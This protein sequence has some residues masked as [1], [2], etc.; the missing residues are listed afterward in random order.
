MKTYQILLVVLCVFFSGRADAAPATGP[1]KDA[2][3]A[4]SP[5][6]KPSVRAP[7]AVGPAIGANTATPV[8]RIKAMKDFKVE[9]IYSV[10][11][12]THGSW[13]NLCNDDKGRIYASD[14]YG[15]LFRLTPPPA[16]QPLDPAK[17]EKVPANIRAVNGMA[18][19]FGASTSA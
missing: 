1:A 2:P 9:L 16:G 11:G 6:R 17:V 4:K 19:A 13:V 15:G 18:F 12:A 3:P 8:S 7:D 10:P 5:A 14:Q